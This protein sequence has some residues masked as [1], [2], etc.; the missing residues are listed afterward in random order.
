MRLIYGTLNEADPEPYNFLGVGRATEGRDF[1]PLQN[2]IIFLAN[3]S[4]ANI[5]LQVL[6]DEDPE[7]DEIVF[8]KLISVELMEGEQER[9]SKTLTQLPKYSEYC[10]IAYNHLGQLN[11]AMDYRQMS[12]V[13][14]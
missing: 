1:I 14:H 7:R 10:V 5:T 3:Q 12:Y 4:E 2:S 13:K 11:K 6:D 8:L 9:F